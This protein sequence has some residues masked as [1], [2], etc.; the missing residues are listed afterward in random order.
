MPTGLI[1]VLLLVALLH[2]AGGVFLFLIARDPHGWRKWRE[3]WSG[4]SL[5]AVI[6]DERVWAR[7]Q[8]QV[9]ILCGIIVLGG[10]VFILIVSFLTCAKVDRE[11]RELREK[12]EAM[13]REGEQFRHQYL[14]GLNFHPEAVRTQGKIEAESKPPPSHERK[15]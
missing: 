13:Q 12:Q 15:D 2:V 8:S 10:G 6:T 3:R 4:V 14:E 9:A 1:L 7:R 5:D 11:E